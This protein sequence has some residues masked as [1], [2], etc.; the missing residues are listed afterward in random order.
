MA[1]GL[2][3]FTIVLIDSWFIRD[4]EFAIDDDNLEIS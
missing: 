1:S 4:L 3:E 2:E